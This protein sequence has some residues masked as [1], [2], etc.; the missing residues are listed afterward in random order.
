M[1][2]GMIVASAPAPQIGVTP[3]PIPTGQL[4]LP[5]QFRDLDGVLLTT[6]AVEVPPFGGFKAQ[7]LER[8]MVPGVSTVNNRIPAETRPTFWAAASFDD[9]V[10]AASL[11][12]SRSPLQTPSWTGYQPVAIVQNRDGAFAITPLMSTDRSWMMMADPAKLGARNGTQTFSRDNV[13]LLAV[14]GGNWMADM[15][16]VE[17]GATATIR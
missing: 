10:Q 4:P 11:L 2:H 16:D 3:K 12:S 8:Q 14:I 9:A 15:R 17:V 7:K 13:A 6:V 1:D 5:Q